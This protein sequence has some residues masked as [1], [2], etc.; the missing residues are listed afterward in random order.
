[1]ATACQHGLLILWDTNTLT[2]LNS[3]HTPGQPIYKLALSH[4]TNDLAFLLNSPN[5]LAFYTGNC[6][7]IAR[8]APDDSTS[9]KSLCF[10]NQTEGLNVN[11][12]A[13]GLSNGRIRLYS[14]WDLSLLR[15]LDVQFEAA[16]SVG[17]I[18][19]VVFTRDRLYAADTYAK[20]Y[21]LESAY[22]AAS[23]VKNGFS[24]GGQVI[25]SSVSAGYVSHFSCFS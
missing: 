1:M 17:C 13:A 15:E 5:Q 25:G 24:V 2:F 19:S 16:S 22:S 3:I 11:V 12:I 4:T 6:Q 9:I 8:T 23:L 14:T 18:I 10:S 20:V 21:V 7:L